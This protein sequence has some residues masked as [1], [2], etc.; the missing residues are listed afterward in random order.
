MI[1]FLINNVWYILFICGTLCAVFNSAI[2]IAVLLRKKF[3]FSCG[4]MFTEYIMLLCVI[5]VM[6]KRIITD[7]CVLIWFGIFVLL[8]LLLQL[9]FKLSHFKFV[10]V[11]GIQKKMHKR[12]AQ[13]LSDCAEY[14]GMN[15]TNMYIYGG[16]A[17]TPCNMIIFKSAPKKITKTVLKDIN[18]FLKQ[19]SS[20]SAVH[21]FLLLCLDIAV[22]FIMF[23][24]M[25]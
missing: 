25:R 24:G 9:R 13:Y 2:C 8:W 5:F 20:P 18:R 17:K 22:V 15:R 16:D 10:R 6:L 14:N 7:E 19:Y 1:D 3:T 4:Y 12:L 21:E 23:N 11:Y